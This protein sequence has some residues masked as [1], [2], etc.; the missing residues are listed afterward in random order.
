M[1]RT[2]EKC[3]KVQT[4]QINSADWICNEEWMNALNAEFKERVK[5]STNQQ[6]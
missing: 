5:L 4:K 3:C 1:C 6:H 2:N